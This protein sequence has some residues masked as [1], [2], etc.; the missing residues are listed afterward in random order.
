MV[1]S[2]LLKVVH[3]IK[4]VPT[5]DFHLDFW[6][7]KSAPLTQHGTSEQSHIYQYLSCPKQ[8]TNGSCLP[9]A[10]TDPVWNWL[11]WHD[12]YRFMDK[13]RYSPATKKVGGGAHSPIHWEAES[14]PAKG[15]CLPQHEGSRTR[16]NTISTEDLYTKLDRTPQPYLF[17]RWLWGNPKGESEVVS[18]SFSI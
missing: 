3:T 9:C 1:L 16:K 8:W 5:R 7:T 15:A 17:K 4:S 18:N 12:S 6:S 2:P 13:Y 10:T 14:L 11:C